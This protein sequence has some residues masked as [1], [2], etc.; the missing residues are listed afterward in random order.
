M[1]IHVVSAG[2]TAASIAERYGVSPRRLAEDNSVPEALDAPAEE[3]GSG[4]AVGQTL[5]VRFP[6]QVHAVTAGETLAAIAERYG[7]T[8]RQLWREA[9]TRWQWGRTW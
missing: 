8:V 5:V 1:T 4:L 2:E 9:G 3:A 7:T 6:R